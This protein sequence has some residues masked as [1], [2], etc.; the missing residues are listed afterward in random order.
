MG[1]GSLCETC[2]CKESLGCFASTGELSNSI[3][4]SI[5]IVYLPLCNTL[6]LGPSKG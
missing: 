6:G 3:F 4:F 2:H 1:S 5:C